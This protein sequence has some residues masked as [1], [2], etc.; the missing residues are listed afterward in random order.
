MNPRHVLALVLAGVGLLV[1]DRGPAAATSPV[2]VRAS[3]PAVVA[4]TPA[5]ALVPA[6][7]W[8][9]RGYDAFASAVS[10][11]RRMVQLMTLIAALALFII[12]W[13]K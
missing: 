3:A 1:C 10:N 11:Q 8:W 7:S 5:P 2:S 4:V 6:V 9:N 12:W 13:R